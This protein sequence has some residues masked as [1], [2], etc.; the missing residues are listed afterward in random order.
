MHVS[1][2]SCCRYVRRF[3]QFMYLMLFTFLNVLLRFKILI[4]AARSF[5]MLVFQKVLVLI[6]VTHFSMFWL[7][8]W[9]VISVDRED[10]VMK[11]LCVRGTGGT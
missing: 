3:K 9:W 2:Y 7:V 8:M 4:S 11:L 6:L 5:I 1:A 10:P